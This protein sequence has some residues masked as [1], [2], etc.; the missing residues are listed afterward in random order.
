MKKTATKKTAKKTVSPSPAAEIPAASSPK[1]RGGASSEPKVSIDL[2][3]NTIVADCSSKSDS[4]EVIR[5]AGYVLTDRAFALLQSGGK[6]VV[7][8]TL[9]LKEPGDKKALEDLAQTFKDE[10]A[11]QRLRHQ[12]SKNNVS[13]R[14]YIV[15]QAVRLAQQPADSE[16]PAPQAPPEPE[17]TEDQRKEIER[18]I[19][20]VEEE[21][22]TMAPNKAAQDPLK[23]SATWE[24][25][26]APKPEEKK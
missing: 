19:A 21:I 2:K 1:G 23:I 5:S 4:L 10:L 6:D 12:I 3:A 9:Q 22:R 26:H 16:A 8:V 11:T 15:E 13:I 25:T 20:E 18:L 14:E 24:E 7:R 17:L